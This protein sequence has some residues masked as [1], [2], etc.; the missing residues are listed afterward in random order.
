MGMDIRTEAAKY[1]DCNPNRDPETMRREWCT[2]VDRVSWQIPIE[3]GTLVC[4][5]RRARMDAEKLVMRCYYPDEFE[6]LVIG[7]GFRVTGR[8]GGYRGEPYGEGR[9]LILQF[10][11]NG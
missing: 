10:D 9:E 8:W 7:H 3:S 6:Q 5:D 1:Y 2:D 11:R 4:Y